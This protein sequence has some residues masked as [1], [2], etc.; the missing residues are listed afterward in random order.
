[1]KGGSKHKRH[2]NTIK[3]LKNFSQNYSKLKIQVYSISA[4]VVTTVCERSIN[5]QATQKHYIKIF[6][7][8]LLKNGNLLKIRV[9]TVAAAGAVAVYERRLKPQVT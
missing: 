2:R 9:Y 6:K 8:I 5:T 7:K 3:I 1:M 4:V